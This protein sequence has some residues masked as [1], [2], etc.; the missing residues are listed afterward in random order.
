[1][2]T[3]LWADFFKT[4]QYAFTGDPLDKTLNTKDVVG[5]GISSPDSIPS[6]SPDGSFWGGADSRVVRS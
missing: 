4:Y 6:M 1:M 2:P 5:A 3:P